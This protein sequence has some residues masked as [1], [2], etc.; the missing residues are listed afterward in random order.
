MAATVAMGW[1]EKPQKPGGEPVFDV[2]GR[3]CFIPSEPHVR[4]FSFVP[5]GLYPWVLGPQ[6]MEYGPQ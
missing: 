4:E 3:A 6:I 2:E 1:R 5:L